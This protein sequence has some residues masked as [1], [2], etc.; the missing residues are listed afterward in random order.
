MNKSRLDGTT[1]KQTDAAYHTIK[2]QMK[3][4]PVTV[5]LKRIGDS[6]PKEKEVSWFISVTLNEKRI[7]YG[8][9]QKSKESWLGALAEQVKIQQYVGIKLET[10]VGLAGVHLPESA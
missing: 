1:D 6:W 4:K 8:S 2:E 7:C 3:R 9:T 10:D 5:P